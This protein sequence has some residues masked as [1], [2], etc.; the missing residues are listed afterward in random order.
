MSTTAHH[1]LMLAGVWGL[2]SLS[3]LKPMPVLYWFF[4]F[5]LFIYMLVNW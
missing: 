2:V 5:A 4:G 3:L 1:L